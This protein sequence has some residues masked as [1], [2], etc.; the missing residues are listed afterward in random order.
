MA[1]MLDQRPVLH[2]R[3][4]ATGLLQVAPDMITSVSDSVSP[5]LSPFLLIFIT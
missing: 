5:I 2:N 3:L 4:V 1:H